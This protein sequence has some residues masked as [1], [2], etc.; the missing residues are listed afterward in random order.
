MSAK[1]QTSSSILDSLSKTPFEEV[2]FDPERRGSGIKKLML[3]ALLTAGAALA[4]YFALNQI[5][6]SKPL[7]PASVAV[8]KAPQI[9]ASATVP[10]AYAAPPPPVA[11]PEKSPEVRKI[12]EMIAAPMSKEAPKAEPKIAPKSLEKP[13]EKLT[14]KPVQKTA[15]KTTEKPVQKPVQTLVQKPT[16]PPVAKAPS[17][18][19]KAAARTDAPFSPV[20]AGTSARSRQ[21]NLD[22]DVDL[23]AAVMAHGRG[24]KPATSAVA[25]VPQAAPPP[26]TLQST[27][28]KSASTI[29]QLVQGCDSQPNGERLSCVRTIC[30]GS[31]GKANACPTALAPR[32]GRVQKIN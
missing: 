8:S 17:Q 10:P 5:N 27:V 13:V 12:E 24:V 29:A 2:A 32:A 23:I 1:N 22:R 14:Q 25:T 6:A 4:A 18:A 15:Q 19:P 11:A 16:P 30:E 9:E 28:P 26:G 7:T 21:E 3:G 31:W 20:T